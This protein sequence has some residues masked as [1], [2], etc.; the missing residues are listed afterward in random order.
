MDDIE[1]AVR[2]SLGEALQ[3]QRTFWGDIENFTSSVNWRD[4]FVVGLLI[5]QATIFVASLLS[6]NRLALQTVLFT[7]IVTLLFAAQTL[8]SFASLRWEK[9]TDANYFDEHG[10]F[11][12]IVFCTPLLLSTVVN[13]TK[14]KNNFFLGI[15]HFFS[16]IV[17]LV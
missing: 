4:R 12:G 11:A 9:F 6:H 17:P 15:A 8:N 16:D 2:K 10:V 13:A 14:K 7:V 5:F 1:G 3:K